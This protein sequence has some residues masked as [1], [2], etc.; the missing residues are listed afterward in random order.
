VIESVGAFGFWATFSVRLCQGG[1]SS[2]LSQRKRQ[3]QQILAR[4]D[5]PPA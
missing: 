1:K 4:L 2:A 3:A 5:L